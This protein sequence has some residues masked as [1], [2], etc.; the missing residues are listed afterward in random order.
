[1]A[2][3]EATARPITS[4][5][6][7]LNLHAEIYKLPRPVL[8]AIIDEA[9]KHGLKTTVHIF[10]EDTAISVLEAGADGLEHGV[11]NRRLTSNRLIDLLQKKSCDLC[12]HTLD[13][14]VRSHQCQPKADLRC[15]AA[16][17]IGHRQLLRPRELGRK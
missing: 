14:R 2:D 17:C 16:N 4:R 5:F 6:R 11:V 1:M 13:R 3:A 12:A 8:D 7:E 10:D 9:R 15:R